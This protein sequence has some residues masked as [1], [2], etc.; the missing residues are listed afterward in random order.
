MFSAEPINIQ[1]STVRA[2]LHDHFRGKIKE[3]VRKINEF[4]AKLDTDPLMAMTWADDVYAA[5]A[6]KSTAETV[7]YLLEHFTELSEVLES[8]FDTVRARA[9]Y[10]N[11]KSTSVSSNFM[12]ENM[13]AEVT[14]AY[15]EISNSIKYHEK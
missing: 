10:I 2:I 4:K 14:Q 12:G 8:L 11:N 7:I 5:T 3:S 6:R 13:L 15:E 1:A 9:R